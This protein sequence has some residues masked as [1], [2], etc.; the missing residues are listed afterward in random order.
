MNNENQENMMTNAE[1]FVD[2]SGEVLCCNSSE[3][4][5]C[6]CKCTCPCTTAEPEADW[7][8]NN[9]S[10]GGNSESCGCPCVDNTTPESDWVSNQGAS[11][12]GSD[13]CC[14][15]CQE[16]NFSVN[17]LWQ[18]RN[19]TEL[20]MKKTDQPILLT[21]RF[22]PW[23]TAPRT[24]R[25]KSS[26]SGVVRV[27][28]DLE[29]ETWAHVTPYENG[30]A[31]ISLKTADDDVVRDTLKITVDSRERVEVKDEGEYF[32]V[33]F[34]EHEGENGKVWKSVCCDVEEEYKGPNIWDTDESLL[35]TVARNVKY[36][37]YQTYTPKQLAL[38]YRLDPLGVVFYVKNRSA[39]MELA[40]GLL[41]KDEVYRAIFKVKAG[42]FYFLPTKSGLL[43]YDA[44]SGWERVEVFS[45]AEFLFGK[46]SIPDFDWFDFIKGCIEG[47]F[48]VFFPDFMEYVGDAKACHALFAAS[49]VD[50]A[51]SDMSQR[52][53]KKCMDEKY[54][55]LSK[56][57]EKTLG[58][59]FK[60]LAILFEIGKAAVGA[61]EFITTTDADV[62]RSLNSSNYR[63]LLKG[64]TK[65]MTLEE[66]LDSYE[67]R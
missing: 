23:G 8:E 5:G 34:V 39:K 66:F 48:S 30:E 19:Y 28:K 50:G 31:I 29:K 18:G 41:Y 43:N 47:V 51:V 4:C 3:S 24:L 2:N 6:R 35:N 61:I 36:N 46:H 14:C 10:E 1:E 49:A 40:A 11:S 37:A 12:G 22:F 13:E 60:P 45:D 20:V 32:T 9:E 53:I 64:T 67:E 56:R 27:V 54:G 16:E 65:T 25:W 58:V 26:D 17:I 63:I 42:E 62:Y 21:A 52:F 44:Y 59:F 38:L 57:I 55:S 15:T 7:T 33:T